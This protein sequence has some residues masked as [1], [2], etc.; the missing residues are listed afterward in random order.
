MHQL[1]RLFPPG[2]QHVNTTKKGWFRTAQE[3]STWTQFRGPK[4]TKRRTRYVTSTV[5]ATVRFFSAGPC[6]NSKRIHGSATP[7]RS[8]LAPLHTWPRC[9]VWLRL[10]AH[11]GVHFGGQK[12]SLKGLPQELLISRDP[13]SGTHIWNQFLALVW[14]PNWVQNFE[15]AGSK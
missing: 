8:C 14:S 7:F 2:L 13:N 10:H 6:A 4:T 15:S 11:P 3:E 5:L 12:R 1:Q 9:R